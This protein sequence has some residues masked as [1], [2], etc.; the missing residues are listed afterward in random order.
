MGILADGSKCDKVFDLDKWFGDN[1][2]VFAAVEGCSVD[3]IFS[4]PTSVSVFD[5]CFD[6][7]NND[8]STLEVFRLTVELELF[9]DKE[10]VGVS[11]VEIA[12]GGFSIEILVEEGADNLNIGLDT[13]LLRFGT[14]NP[15]ENND[16]AFDVVPD[17]DCRFA[18]PVGSLAIDCSKEPINDLGFT[19]T[20][21]FSEFSE[22][23]I[24]VRV[25]VDVDGC[26]IKVAFNVSW[27]GVHTV[28]STF[29]S[30][31]DCSR[32]SLVVMDCTFDVWTNEFTLSFDVSRSAE[33]FCDSTSK[34]II[35]CS[36]VEG[37]VDGCKVEV[38]AKCLKRADGDNICSGE[39]ALDCP[40]SDKGNNCKFMQ[41]DDGRVWIVNISNGSS[42]V[43]C[44]LGF[45]L[46]LKGLILF[47][48]NDWINLGIEEVDLTDCNVMLDPKLDMLVDTLDILNVLVEPQQGFSWYC[49]WNFTYLIILTIKSSVL[50]K[51]RKNPGNFKNLS[52]FSSL[53]DNCSSIVSKEAR[54]Y[55]MCIS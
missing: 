51:T 54:L 17:V 47:G 35:V 11:N 53:S 31:L 37:D 26:T 33:D 29:W 7:L 50:I 13:D 27:E 49:S 8:N 25:P 9:G 43:V 24:G 20:F 46:A 39:L 14:C 4:G 5:D 42:S 3:G 16:V 41:G 44:S 23:V 36:K 10:L 30:T 2:T 34:R 55:L 22:A 6:G 38:G 45:A 12:V 1:F 15:E 28:V 19:E 52:L 18:E 48:L 32:S 40:V 21:K